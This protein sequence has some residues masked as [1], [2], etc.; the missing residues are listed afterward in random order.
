MDLPY[1]KSRVLERRNASS[2]VPSI[3]NM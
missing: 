3:F 2:E 1:E